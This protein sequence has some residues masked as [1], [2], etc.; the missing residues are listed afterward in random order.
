MNERLKES[1]EKLRALATSRRGRNVLTFFVFLL[2]STAFWFILALNNETQAEFEIPLNLTGIPDNTT[3]ITNIP[4]TVSVSVKDKGTSLLRYQWGKMP[5]LDVK[6][7]DFQKDNRH[8]TLGGSQFSGIV[9]SFLGPTAT[10]IDLKPDSLSLYYTTQP[11][12][13]KRVYSTIEATASPQHII[14]GEIRL[15]PDS[16]T[17]YSMNKISSSLKIST[18]SL[19]LSG[20]TDSTTVEVGVMAPDGT[21]AIP[22]TVKAI[23][24]VEPLIAKKRAIPVEIMNAPVDSKI[25]LFPSS[26]EI[27]YLVPISVYNNDDYIVK[28]YAQYEPNLKKLPV[29]LSI[30]PSVYRNVDFATDSVEY[31]VE[32]K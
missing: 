3:V 24:P 22:S 7:S 15:I 20:L 2:I 1:K 8:I 13:M 19:I 18:D 28:A 21:K 4:S 29:H 11:G 9:R 25:L 6:F 26:I 27:S 23:I 17:I 12:V 16:V 14:S 5:Q 31:V 10:V 30:L 32:H